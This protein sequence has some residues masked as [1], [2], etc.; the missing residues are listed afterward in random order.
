MKFYVYWSVDVVMAAA[1][2]SI[3]VLVHDNILSSLFLGFHK[4]PTLHIVGHSKTEFETLK[5]WCCSLADF[6]LM[7]STNIDTMFSDLNYD[8]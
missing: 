3:E 6:V 2:W 4:K 7:L 5:T 8:K 1:A